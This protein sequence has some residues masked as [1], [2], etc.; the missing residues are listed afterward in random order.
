ML[1]ERLAAVLDRRLEPDLSRPLVV[2]L[3]GG[4]D[5]LALLQL[6]AEWARS[7]RRPLLALTV[8]HR[9]HPDS[10]DWTKRA[11][12]MAERAGA[13]WQGLAWTGEKPF[14]GVSAAAREARHALIAEAARVAGAHVVLMA[15][16][17]DDRAEA[18][19][20]RERGSTLGQL[21]EWAP[22]PAWPEGRGL[23]LLRPLLETSRADLR[24]WLSSRRESWIEDPANESLASLRVQARVAL[25]GAQPEPL[26][27]DGPPAEGLKV[28]AGVVTAP[29]GTP[30][31]SAVLTCAAG[32]AGP[33]RADRLA[34]LAARLG[35]CEPLQAT[36]SGAVLGSDGRSLTVTREPGRAPPLDLPL[37]PGEVQVWDGRWTVETMEPGWI[38]GLADG[39]RSR[40]SRDDRA[41][42]DRLPAIARA[43]HP[44][45]FRGDGSS[46]VL[47]SDAV[48]VRDLVADRL[49]LTT[50]GAPREADLIPPAMAPNAMASYL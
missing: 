26:D 38:V 46:P 19:W 29:V 45:L 1:S 24:A 8:D 22:S 5:S 11:R 40:L 37:E 28:E 47:A 31:L 4:G 30:W 32:A 27:D 44:V 36:L 16:T 18:D 35:T 25:G 10:E 3:S 49:R 9:L 23:M 17:A 48:R 21:R 42:L 14:T 6:T 2:A 7:R 20:M 33:V 50:G 41:W 15:H 43:G 12:Q 39:R 13:D 34:A